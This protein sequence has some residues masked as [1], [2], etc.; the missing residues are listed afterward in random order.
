M[1]T[2]ELFAC[3]SADRPSIGRA[4]RHIFADAIKLF[5]K[6]IMPRPYSIDLRQRVV[7][8]VEQDG[9]SR[10]E[11]AARFGVAVSTAIIWVARLD[12]FLFCLNR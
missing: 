4:A 12:R 6:A 2:P 10:H 11:A 5:L 1:C 8:A 3:S 7:A 9:L